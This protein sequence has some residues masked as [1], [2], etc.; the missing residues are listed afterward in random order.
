MFADQMKEIKSQVQ[1]AELKKN[2][3]ELEKFILQKHIFL[4]DF[5]KCALLG[6][7][8]SQLK[9]NMVEG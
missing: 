8:F 7:L 2:L 3:S 4:T 5:R 6:F 9:M 1:V